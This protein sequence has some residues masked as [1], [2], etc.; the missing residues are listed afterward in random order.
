MSSPFRGRVER[1]K[2]QSEAVTKS[3]FALI[4]TRKVF[5][6]F[7]AISDIAFYWSLLKVPAQI[8]FLAS[9]LPHAF[10][11]LRSGPHRHRPADRQAAQWMNI[12]T[13]LFTIVVFGVAL[14]KA[15]KVDSYSFA[16]LVIAVIAK[17]MALRPDWTC[18]AQRLLCVALDWIPGWMAPHVN[19]LKS[20]L[21]R[22]RPLVIDD[23]S[24]GRQLKHLATSIH[25]QTTTL[26]FFA[27]G[28]GQLPKRWSFLARDCW[29]WGLGV[30]LVRGLMAVTNK[31]AEKR[32][33]ENDEGYSKVGEE[34]MD[35]LDEADRFGLIDLALGYC[36]STTIAISLVTIA[37]SWIS[38][39]ATDSAAVS[40]VNVK[41]I[42][43]ISFAW[44]ALWVVHH[45][46]SAFLDS[47]QEEDLTMLA[48][49][50]KAADE[51]SKNKRRIGRALIL[52]AAAPMI[53]A[54]FKHGLS[55]NALVSLSGELNGLVSNST[56]SQTLSLTFS[57]MAFIEAVA[58]D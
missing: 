41:Y 2:D 30:L 42:S 31:F 40:F 18:T 27:D 12:G 26:I 32:D 28:L 20:R 10:A 7:E 19:S 49:Q 15:R 37:P 39:G 58:F 21:P 47:N 8:V 55:G 23:H 24:V 52:I 48:S 57:G 6:I 53:I 43:M 14:L 51:T 44:T 29:T 56:R 17:T 4:A 36:I 45:R 50:T 33:R 3:C 25:L 34:S 5:S 1:H 13:P 35:E 9:I 16:Q 46:S 54:T 22:F 38:L 11:L